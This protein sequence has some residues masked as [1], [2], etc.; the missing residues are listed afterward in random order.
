MLNR[1]KR[2][3]LEFRNVHPI[4]YDIRMDQ[5]DQYLNEHGVKIP[6]LV[7]LIE[8][9]PT[10]LEDLLRFKELELVVVASDDHA[11]EEGCQGAG[12]NENQD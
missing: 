12:C 3:R 2:E 7:K 9:A 1:V 10:V 5:D 4:E 11:Y 8:E 6:W